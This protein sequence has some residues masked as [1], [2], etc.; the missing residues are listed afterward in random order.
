MARHIVR[1]MVVEEDGGENISVKY[2]TLY[3]M[4]LRGWHQRNFKQVRAIYYRHPGYTYYDARSITQG[5]WLFMLFMLNF[6]L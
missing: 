6:S 2:D 1:E 5:G 4:E 3:N